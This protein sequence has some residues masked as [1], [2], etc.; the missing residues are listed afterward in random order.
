MEQELKFLSFLGY[1]TKQIPGYNGVGWNVLDENN[2]NVGTI[3]KKRLHKAHKTKGDEVF[4]YVTKI[5]SDKISYKKLRRLDEEDATFNYDFAIKNSDGNNDHVEMS[6]GEYP[7]ISIWSK[8]Y[9]FMSFYLYNHILFI[10]FADATE[11]FNTEQIIHFDWGEYDKEYGDYNEQY[12]YQITYCKKDTD[13]KQFS[14]EGKTTREIKAEYTPYFRPFNKINLTSY[15]WINGKLKTPQT[16]I[17]DGTIYEVIQKSKLG[18]EA[19]DRF[20]FIL[21]AILPFKDDA[22]NI[23]LSDT[24]NLDLEE[25][26]LELFIPDIIE[27]FKDK[28]E[29]QVLTLKNK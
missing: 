21:N 18:I 5:D 14:S 1:T 7:N 23:L 3:R 6:V 4:A 27:K 9:G 13:L 22:M 29:Q 2:N 10:D 28:N 8:E 16:N 11:N 25:K 17:Y 19:M 24:P 12:T 26:S 15:T 20:R